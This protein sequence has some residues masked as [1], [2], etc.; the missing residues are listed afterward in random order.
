MK[1]NEGW[2]KIEDQIDMSSAVGLPDVLN[3]RRSIPPRKIRRNT[4]RRAETMETRRERSRGQRTSCPSRETLRDIENS[5]SSSEA[6]ILILMMYSPIIFTKMFEYD[7]ILD[8]I[9]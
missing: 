3:R 8:L 6:V 1:I 2:M 5:L 7:N 4:K 9:R